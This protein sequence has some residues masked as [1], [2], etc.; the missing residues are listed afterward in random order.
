MGSV[1]HVWDQYGY[2]WWS[3]KARL[4]VHAYKVCSAGPVGA[5]DIL[6]AKLLTM[7]RT[8]VVAALDCESSSYLQQGQLEGFVPRAGCSHVPAGN[9]TRS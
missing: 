2:T 5:G 3:D 9:V 6:A 7:P 8:R 4:E 1:W